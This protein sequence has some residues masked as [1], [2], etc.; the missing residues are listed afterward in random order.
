MLKAV[1]GDAEGAIELC[2]TGLAHLEGTG[3]RQMYGSTLAAL[4][5]VLALTGRH[6]ESL[7]PLRRALDAAAE[8][9]EVL[10]AA[11][12][13]MGLAWH[14]ARED[15]PVRACRLLGFADE[16]ARRLSGDPVTLLPRLLEEHDTVRKEVRAALGAEGFERWWETGARMS[17]RQVLDAVRSDADPLPGAEPLAVRPRALADVLT[18]REVEVA[19]LVAEGLSNREIAERLVISKRT[20]DAHVEHILAK[21]G[22]TSR[23]EIPAART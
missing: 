9:G 5:I 11:L 6:E 14:A 21:L 18:R 16:H 23:T 19:G 13:C 20:V 12:A 15:R 17:G 4:G 7:D 3:D 1:L 22:I 8:I 10:I 2:R